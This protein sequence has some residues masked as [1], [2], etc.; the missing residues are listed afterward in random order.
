M[1]RSIAILR[2]NVVNTQKD[3]SL[4]P[5]TLIRTELR[6]GD[7][8]YLVYLHGMLYAKECGW[9]HTFE[10]YVAGPLSEFAKTSGP[11]NRIWI[12]ER[13]EEVAGSIAIVELEHNVAQLRWFLLHPC[14]RG[15]GLGK[16]LLSEAVSFC[17]TSGYSSVQLW[18]VSTLTA[19]AHLYGAAGFIIAEERTRPL[20][21]KILTEQRYE[22]RL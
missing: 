20:W 15:M 6:P 22:L 16:R 19:A 14:L 1:I 21:G 18:T 13:S 7:I 11:R 4:P 10:A 8:G 12:V 9:D 17:R 2:S 3:S 5:S